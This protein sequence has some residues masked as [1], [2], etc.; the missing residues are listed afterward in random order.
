MAMIH[1]R[2]NILNTFIKN[3]KRYIVLELSQEDRLLKTISSKYYFYCTPGS[4][5]PTNEYQDVFTG[6]LEECNQKFLEKVNELVSM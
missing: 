2:E 5:V 6:T 4:G 1:V 3:S